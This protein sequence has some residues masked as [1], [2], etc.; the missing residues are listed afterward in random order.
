MEI[1]LAN[2]TISSQEF[3]TPCQTD[4]WCSLMSDWT[5]CS[6]STFNIFG[7]ACSCVFHRHQLHLLYRVVPCS[8]MRRLLSVLVLSRLDY[9]NAILAKLLSTTLYPL[10]QIQCCS[11]SHFFSWCSGP[12]DRTVDGAPLVT[13]QIPYQFKVVSDDVCCVT[14]QWL[15]YICDI[16]ILHWHYLSGT[17]FKLLRVAS[18]ISPGQELFSGKEHSP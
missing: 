2:H 15:E 14:V 13:N 17:C 1:L 8:T 3:L 6:P 5:V 7:T 10:R 9:C 12:I 18:S 11:L 16:V 4:S